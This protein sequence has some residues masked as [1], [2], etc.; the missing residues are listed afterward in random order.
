MCSPLSQ[1]EQAPCHGLRG[2]RVRGKPFIY[3][4]I[5]ERVRGD[6]PGSAPGMLSIYGQCA[7]LLTACPGHRAALCSSQLSP[8]LCLATLPHPSAGTTGVGMALALPDSCR[9]QWREDACLVRQADWVSVTQREAIVPA[10]HRGSVGRLLHAWT[11]VA[12]EGHQAVLGP[13]QLVSCSVEDTRMRLVT[14]LVLSQDDFFY[15]YKQ[16]KKPSDLG[17]AAKVICDKMNVTMH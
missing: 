8:S 17:S 5:A 1:G 4:E 14:S 15:S 10:A 3:R 2:L 12:R 6:V 16:P 9:R 7:N 11:G 13:P